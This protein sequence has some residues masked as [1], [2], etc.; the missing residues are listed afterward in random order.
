MPRIAANGLEFEYEEFGKR[1]SPP[2][3]L[4]MGLGAQMITWDDEFCEAI[5]AKGFRVIRYDNRDIGLS[6]HLDHHGMPDLAGITSGEVEPPYSLDD[7]AADGIHLLQALG[8][9]K[10]HVVGASM[11]GMIVQLMA[12]NH[13]QN[14]LSL[15]SIMSTTGRGATPPTA[16]ALEALTATPQFEREAYIEQAVKGGRVFAGPSFD[17]VRARQRASRS[18]DRAFHPLGFARQYAAILA[19]PSRVEALGKLQIPTLVIHGKD[20][21]LV[22]PDNG[23][24]THRAVPEAELMMLDGM[25]HNIPQNHWD[26]VATAIAVNAAKARVSA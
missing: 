24:M 3:L 18:F 1:S 7:M 5:A 16:E 13:P 25:G 6:S 21:T 19:A 2:L 17:E 22:P 23:L 11:G 26:T 4:V 8:I 10:A 15:T 12:I 20:D 9:D 14:V